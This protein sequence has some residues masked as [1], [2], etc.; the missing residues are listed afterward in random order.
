MSYKRIQLGL[1]LYY[2]FVKLTNLL[3]PSGRGPDKELTSKFLQKINI[4]II[5]QCVNMNIHRL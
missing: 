5:I 3:N 4:N 1:N 2:M